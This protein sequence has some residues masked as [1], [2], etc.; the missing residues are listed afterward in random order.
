[1][2]LVQDLPSGEVF[3]ILERNYPSKLA[4]SSNAHVLARYSA[5]STR[6]WHGSNC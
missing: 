1:M 5:L 6:E 2:I 3:I 4:I